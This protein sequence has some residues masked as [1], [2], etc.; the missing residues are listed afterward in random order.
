MKIK[1]HPFSS[2]VSLIVLV[3]AMVAPLP[4]ARMVTIEPVYAAPS[5]CVP[6]PHFGTISADEQWCQ[7]D[8]P[9]VMSNNV[10]VAAGVT[11]TIEPGVT[12]QAGTTAVAL[13]VEGHLQAV[14]T[15]AQP[16]IF[17]SQTDSAPGQW[18]G[19]TIDGGTGTLEHVI[20]RYAG[21]SV[22]T[23]PG[24]ANS[25]AIS[26]V[27]V[28]TGTVTIAASQILS[29]SYSTNHDHGLCI[30]DSH[31]V[32]SDTLFS[33][34]GD[35]T[36]QAEYPL[37]IGGPTSDVQLSG[38]RLENNVYNRVM[39]LEGA[40]TGHDFTLTAQPA[41]D[42][43]EFYNSALGSDF[44]VPAGVTMT[45]EPGVT[46]I[47]NWDINKT[48]VIQGHLEAVG[49]EEQPIIFTSH[50]D[51]APYQWHGLAFDGG[52]GNLQHAI[53]RY[54]GRSCY[55]CGAYTSAAIMARGV[56]TGTLTIAASQIM[57]VT[58]GTGV[59]NQGL[60]VE[61]SRVA[62]TDTLFTAIGDDAA[63]TDYPVYISGPT[64]DVTLSGLWLENNQYD[65]VMLDL[66]ALTGH[67]FTLTAQP[68]M[69]GYEFYNGVAG[70][71]FFVPA[72]VTMTVEPGVT[73]MN[74]FDHN[75]T[76]VIQGHL[77]AVGTE[78]QPIIFTSHTDSGPYQWRGLAFDGG[79]GNLQHAIVRYAGRGSYGITG[80]AAIAAVG[81]QTGTL[82]IAASQVISTSGGS[83]V[84]NYGLYALN[85]RVVV[86]DTLFSAI[87]DS[88]GETAAAVAATG[89]SNLALSDCAIERNAANGLFIDG[90]AQVQIVDTAIVDHGRYGMRVNGNDAVVTMSGSTVLAS[91]QDGVRNSGNAHVT[92]GGA[93][94][95]G[96]SILGNGGYGANQVGTSVQMTAT[97]NWWGAVS[98]PYHATLN[99]DGEGENVS[100][101]V[102]FDPWA[103]DWQGQMPDG[104]Y[105][106]LVGQ[107]QVFPGGQANYTTMY[108][109]G[110]AET[111]ENAVLVMVLPAGASFVNATNG[112]EYWAQR[113]SVVWKLGDV[114]PGDSGTAAVQVQFAWGLP[115]GAVHAA[116]V[117]L[118][119]T[120]LPLGLSHAQ[121]YLDWSPIHLQSST[122]LSAG[123]LAAERAAH[124]DLDLLY[125]QAAADGFVP[126][127]A[128]RLAL[129]AAE[130]VTQ[131]VM[132]RPAGREVLYLR[133][134][135]TQVLA[136]TFGLANYAVHDATGGLSV[137]VQTNAET[138]WGA[139]G[140]GATPSDTGLAY[141]D[142][143]FSYL[144]AMVLQDK[145]TRLAQVLGSATCY[146]CL[147]GGSCT[148]CLAALQAAAPLPEAAEAMACADDS[149]RAANSREVLGR[150]IPCDEDIY[151]ECG[152]NFWGQSFEVIRS[153]S[154]GF[155][156]FRDDQTTANLC[157]SGQT[158]NPGQ[159]SSGAL[160]VSLGCVCSPA[161]SRSVSSNAATLPV[162]GPFPSDAR[163][164]SG[165]TSGE[166][167]GASVCVRTRILSPLDP[168]AKYGIEGDLIPGQRVTYTITYENEGD[169][170]AYG[171]FVVDQ[172]D[173][174]LDMSTVTIYG[175]GE[176]IAE[177]RT[178]LWTVGELGPK[179]DPDSQGVVS[180]T[181]ELLDDLLA[182]TAVVNQAIVYF[183]TVGEET[184]TNPV[185]NLVQ[186]L[187]AVPQ[188]V[189][190]VYGQPLSITLTGRAPV[191]VPLSFEIVEMPLNGDLSGTAPD[192]VYTPA[193]NTS[194]LDRFTFKVTDGSNE[195]SP[196]EVQ[197]VVDPAG[198]LVAPQV[199]S[200]YPLDGAT[201]V[202]IS[203]HPVMSDDV[204]PILAPTLLVQF[205]EAISATTLT[206]ADVQGVDAG[207][208]PL[209]L[210]A[211]YDGVAHRAVVYL[212]EP[213]QLATWYTFT[214]AA[215]VEDVAG[216]SLGAEH[217]WSFR[218]ADVSIAGLAAVNDGPTILGSLTTLTVTV[219]A[220]TNVTYT[221]AL[222]D[223]STASGA[224]V[225]HVYPAID[226]YTATV[227]ATNGSGYAVTTT[228]VTIESDE[229]N[230]YLPLV[231]CDW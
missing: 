63:Q 103:V 60:R 9:H 56:Q 204:G 131:V 217:V 132:L 149:A 159:G 176:L 44:I 33:G 124:P 120:N 111:V 82:T 97:H 100:N 107:R 50:A 126:G 197:I 32:V 37:Y 104:V 127:G 209:S 210:S 115:S 2:I 74:N 166:E 110:R 5:A 112:G 102:L 58:G 36:S 27:D 116:Q 171:V 154:A 161:D 220:G 190:T 6:G 214:V 175:P 178:I 199:R 164:V 129:D 81:V 90:T 106:S 148:R 173:A 228:V 174:S 72:G 93:T 211:L 143:R 167:E 202:G 22:Y 117:R 62:V 61:N 160:N 73:V 147:S 226:D 216:N 10:T 184:P 26:V 85:S 118:G 180:F 142:C 101:R 108:V 17:T 41:L 70:T 200:T 24:G 69:E 205:S 153:C 207:G 18:P 194:G 42:G 38:L 193:E 29:T 198:D 51:S 94:G 68:A 76:L 130:P 146:P 158:C 49:T 152:K 96:N 201:D 95:L 23:C 89:S 140:N 150:V 177:N 86:N 66:G 179:G 223:G 221:W 231:L 134:Q 196:V 54:A 188:R 15:E 139:W 64:S 48:L 40:L 67:D 13:I 45:V 59:V 185:V 91:A 123:E 25:A 163:G 121:D 128:V 11:L 30:K 35:N 218:T 187:A 7:V 135:G 213:L 57:S 229:Y 109:N 222:G 80:G 141:G 14:G 105:V 136:S 79:T 157:Q 84:A 138:F 182:G 19:I 169:G 28:Q 227:T 98:G 137:D 189:V 8:S 78:E 156:V 168:N 20:V 183:P 119:G 225:T 4:V 99:P 133:R 47:N 77:E 16:I 191:S 230:V 3:A 21:R 52:T 206:D 43:Y 125:T 12:V 55:N 122:P 145:L 113:H 162:L 75:Q 65:R 186:P 71:D 195:S 208:N 165:C 144:P 92:L 155:V 87:S 34:I 224:V 151:V 83:T 219:T 172:L 203:A 181:V 88:A 31:V 212:R 46:V 39:L 1:L 114:Q 215:D 170:R 192:L 53:V